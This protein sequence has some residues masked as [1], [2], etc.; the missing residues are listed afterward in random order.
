MTC[1]RCSRQVFWMNTQ[2]NPNIE[3]QIFSTIQFRSVIVQERVSCLKNISADFFRY[4]VY[5]FIWIWTADYVVVNS[6]WTEK[7]VCNSHPIVK[8]SI[9]F[10]ITVDAVVDDE[11]CFRNFSE[12]LYYVFLRFIVHTLT[13]TQ[14]IT[15][16]IAVREILAYM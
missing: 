10:G 1:I 16:Y 11:H 12:H 3:C 5:S 14:Y 6:F 15:Q 8:H 4:L 9:S 13:L 2:S 7:A